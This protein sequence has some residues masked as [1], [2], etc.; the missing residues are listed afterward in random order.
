MIMLTNP[1]FLA[2]LSGFTCGLLGPFFVWRR[3]NFLGDA[4]AHSAM[5][6]L[7]LS[8]ILGVPPIILILPF[9]IL[10]GLFIAFLYLKK[11]G[12]LDSTIAVFF[13]GFM[14]LGLLISQASGAGSEEVLHFIFGDISS[15]DTLGSLLTG[16]IS[17][18]AVA[19][20]LYWRKELLLMVLQKDLAKIEGIKVNWHEVWLLVI[21]A[22]VVTVTLK[23]MGTILLT[24]LLI[25]P[26]VVF[27]RLSGSLMHQLLGS[28]LLGMVLAVS[29]VGIALVF[30]VPASGSVA[31]LSL[32]LFLTA[33]LFF[34]PPSPITS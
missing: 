14:G 30:N 26:P 4:I 6:P 10:F 32:M 12:Q 34:K 29:G 11:S 13:A 15:P 24:S 22:L 8:L 19:H 2:A 16:V 23:L 17:V 20:I 9:N 1:L 28:A 31:G 27:R 7:S 3:L 33:S 25:T 18:A 21:M 5:T